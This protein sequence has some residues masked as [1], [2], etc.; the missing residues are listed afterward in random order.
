MKFLPVELIIEI[1]PSEL[2]QASIRP[3]SYGAQAT[4]LT[5]IN[6]RLKI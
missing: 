1:E 4:V 3:Y 2:P 5:K 6:P